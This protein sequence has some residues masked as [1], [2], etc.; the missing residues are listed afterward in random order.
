MKLML[1]AGARPNFMKIASI[2]DAMKN[3][4][5]STAAQKNAIEPILVHTGQ[6]Y[7]DS[8]SEAF[9]KDFGLPK[10]DIY[11]G[12]GSASHAVQTSE[13]MKRFE[14]VLLKEEPDV[15]MVVGDVNSTIACALVA[16]K[17]QY[18]RNTGNRQH[19]KGLRPLVAHVEAG[20]R[21]FDRT[22]PEEINRILTD[23]VSDFLFTT[24][25]SA[26]ENLRREGIP[27]NKI[28]FVGNTMIDTLLKHNQIAQKSDILNKLG[29]S[30]KSQQPETRVQEQ[31][32]NSKQPAAG[33]QQPATSN[34]KP[35]TS[36]RVVPYAVLTLHRPSNVDKQETFKNILEALL[37]VSK[38]IPIIFPVHPRTL[39]RIREFGFEK[40][41]TFL[42]NDQKRETS[43]QQRAT[44]NEHPAP[45]NQQPATFNLRPLTFGLHCVEP[46]GYLDFLCLMSN[47]KLVLTDSGGI[48]EETTILGIPCITL[49]ENTERPITVIQGTNVI[50]GAGKK[51]IIEESL[52]RIKDLLNN[53]IT[54]VTHYL[55]LWDGKAGQRI[56]SIL[57]N[58]FSERLS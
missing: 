5:C 55:P 28:Y 4:N 33:S 44:S 21:S 2:I 25:G 35:A 32:T 58:H 30:T 46:L 36:N 18:N 29:L 47:A 31:T 7:D 15:V 26:N 40:Y 22:M 10:P 9:F 19:S 8:M 3:Y 45:R 53:P 49:R 37:E 27:K 43:N 1:I 42:S 54:Q 34:Q 50:V 51:R 20:L 48:Q 23:Q 39:N 56:M 11:L 17:I 13:I 52:K 38:R 12:V 57:T 14:P 41:F 6:H 16:S 24:E